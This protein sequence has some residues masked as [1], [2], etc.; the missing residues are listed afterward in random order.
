VKN[1]KNKGDKKVK[2]IQERGNKGVADK[3]PQTR[4]KSRK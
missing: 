1:S 4:E 3:K 2:K